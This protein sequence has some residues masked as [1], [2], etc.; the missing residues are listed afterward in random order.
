MPNVDTWNPLGNL[1]PEEVELKK[2]KAIAEMQAAMNPSAPNPQGNIGGLTEQQY[3]ESL[4][5]AQAP[6]NSAKAV[7]ST[8]DPTGHQLMFGPIAPGQGGVGGG[9]FDGMQVGLGTS[10]VLKLLPASKLTGTAY[11]TSN[12]VNEALG[13][14]AN[15]ALGVVN[16]LMRKAVGKAAVSGTKKATGVDAQDAANNY[17]WNIASILGG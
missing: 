6:Q 5:R 7:H 2:R 9:V 14:A 11:K 15:K 16:P 4:A 3:R 17:L 12:A 13:T 10:G 1:T 8:M